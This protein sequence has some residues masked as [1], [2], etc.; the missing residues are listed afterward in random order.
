[1]STVGGK[2]GRRSRRATLL[3]MT[4]EKSGVAVGQQQNGAKGKKAD[5]DC[6]V[7]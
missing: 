1:M 6:I 7:S 3:G 2:E 4:N 5:G